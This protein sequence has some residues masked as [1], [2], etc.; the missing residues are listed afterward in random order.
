MKTE[1]LSFASALSTVIGLSACFAAPASA[2]S[3]TYVYTGADYT[4]HWSS[5]NDNGGGGYPTQSQLAGWA[6]DL[7]P[8]MNITVTIDTPGNLSGPLNGTFHQGLHEGEYLLTISF[9][10]GL[11]GGS[12]GHFDLD[13]ITIVDG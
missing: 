13:S 3:V 8:H 6:N 9:A 12:Y 4:R 5:Y 7:G 10:S 2:N 1:L 11:A